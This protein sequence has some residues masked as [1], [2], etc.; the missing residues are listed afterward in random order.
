[1]VRSCF[2]KA[3]GLL[4]KQDCDIGILQVLLCSPSKPA[5]Q[6]SRILCK[7][8]EKSAWGRLL[9][10]KAVSSLSRAC[11]FTLNKG[12]HYSDSILLADYLIGFTF[13]F[14]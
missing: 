4:L 14:I 13:C 5:I 3:T 2:N 7:F 9:F 6:K 10:S 1:M 12:V 8:P 11:N